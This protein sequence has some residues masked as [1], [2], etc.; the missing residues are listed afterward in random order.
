MSVF[1]ARPVHLHL[2][3]TY[4]RL[5]DLVCQTLADHGVDCAP[6]VWLS[7]TLDVPAAELR[8]T[9]HY[10]LHL[11]I[12]PDPTGPVL[13]CLPRQPIAAGF[14]PVHRGGR[15]LL[16]LPGCRLRPALGL[17]GQ[18]VGPVPAHERGTTIGA[19]ELAYTVCRLTLMAG[20]WLPTSPDPA[21]YLFELV[22][23]AW[24]HASGTRRLGGLGIHRA[25][26]DTPIAFS[27]GAMTNRLELVTNRHELVN[28]Y[29]IPACRGDR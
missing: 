11:G 16:R 27:A 6:L 24:R 29:P 13:Y 17:S 8:T 21:R 25:S 20:N 10:A 14:V 26:F 2:A 15:M 23:E 22:A 18:R 28:V 9:V 4:L 7:R 12:C 19:G 3:L 5:A 1:T